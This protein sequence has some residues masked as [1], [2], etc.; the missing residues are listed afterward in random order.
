MRNDAP[1]EAGLPQRRRSIQ[2]SRVRHDGLAAG[3]ERPP[4]ELSERA[5]VFWRAVVQYGERK[6]EVEELVSHGWVELVC[7]LDPR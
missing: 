6:D 1:L 7:E 5:P 2:P 4:K 3:R